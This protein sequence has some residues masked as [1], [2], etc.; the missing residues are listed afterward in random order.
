MNGMRKLMAAM[1][2]M[3]AL[4]LGSAFA[5]EEP[6]GNVLELHSCELYAGGCI[7]SSE[8]TQGG[9]Y[10][11]K[12]WSLTGGS[13]G[14]SAVS[15]LQ[16]AV[17]ESGSENLAQPHAQPVDAVVYL[18]QAATEAQRW[19]LLSWV[20]STEAGLSKA[21]VQSRVVP[22]D[23]GRTTDGYRFAAGDFIRVAS[24]PLEPCQT[25]ACGE[26]LWYTPRTHS[27]VF[28]VAVDRASQVTEPLLKLKWS[29]AGK[30]SVFLARMGDG[31]SARNLYV[32]AADLC[33]PGERLF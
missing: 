18:P 1:V 28:T 19:A 23:F 10:M 25:G 24:A 3:S 17:L 29:E 6:R 22:L 8:A 21:R 32:T 15:G 9:R 33:G 11:V 14:G 31:E 4:A 16:V 20:V 5:G 13:F 2:G 30:R 7:V 27:T 12:A 26:A